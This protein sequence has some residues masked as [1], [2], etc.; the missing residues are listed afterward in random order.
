MNVFAFCDAQIK[1]NE[2]LQREN[3][4]MEVCVFLY[5]TISSFN[6]LPVLLQTLWQAYLS[7]ID[8]SKI[9]I[10]FDDEPGFKVSSC[11]LKGYVEHYCAAWIILM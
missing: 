11:L 6:R 9:G 1:D 7:K 4:L 5:F 8:F 2:F 10:E 3:L